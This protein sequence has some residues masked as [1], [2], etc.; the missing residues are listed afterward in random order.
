[1]MRTEVLRALGGWAAAPI[2][3]DIIMFAALS[4]L[5][6]GYNDPAVTWLYRLHDRQTHRTQTSRLLSQAERL[7]ALQRVRALSH[8]PHLA[9]QHR[10]FTPEA[11]PAA[12]DAA[13]PSTPWWKATS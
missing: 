13:D 11:G 1:M 6:P 9:G 7:I 8:L 2:D 5:A 12:K 10:D 3:E 4:E